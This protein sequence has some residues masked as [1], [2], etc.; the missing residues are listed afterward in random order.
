MWRWFFIKFIFAD[1]KT[2]THDWEVYSTA[3]EDVCLELQC[4]KCAILGEVPD[5]TKEEWSKGY[6]APSNPYPWTENERVVVGTV[7]LV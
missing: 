2:C 5:P 4:K 7:Q 6:S 1:P 3:L